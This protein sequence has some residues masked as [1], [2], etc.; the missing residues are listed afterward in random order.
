MKIRLLFVALALALTAIAIPSQ[1]DHVNEPTAPITAIGMRVFDYPHA[2]TM[3]RCDG[4]DV[5]LFDEARVELDV[6]SEVK[7]S[8]HFTAT[9]E[10]YL[11]VP[12]RRGRLIGRYKDQAV[13]EHSNIPPHTP[14]EGKDW[15]HVQSNHRFEDYTGPFTF[16]F[17]VVGD[18]S[19]N[20]FEVICPFTVG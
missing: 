6:R 5:V 8:E 18:E 13:W 15:E 17:R 10:Y 2:V 9:R 3:L 12:D 11:S 4:T 19:G 1:A 7:P 14:T 16:R 20:E